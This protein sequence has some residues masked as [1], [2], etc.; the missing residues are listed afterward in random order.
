MMPSSLRRYWSTLHPLPSRSV[1]HDQSSWL[2]TKRAAW[3][4]RLWASL[5]CVHGVGDGVN[6]KRGRMQDAQIGLLG[7][8]SET[9][10]KRNLRMTISNQRW[11]ISQKAIDEVEV[12]ER[13]TYFDKVVVNMIRPP[14][15]SI[16]KRFRQECGSLTLTRSKDF[17]RE[18]RLVALQP[19]DVA[20]QLLDELF[21][22]SGKGDRVT[23][24]E[25]ALD[26]TTKTKRKANQL[27]AAMCSVIVFQHHG[28]KRVNWCKETRYTSPREWG[29]R[30]LVTYSDRRSKI[31]GMPCL[32]I[33]MRYRG[34]QVV[35]RCGVNRP[36][37]LLAI[38]KHQYWQRYL[39]LR[40]V[41]VHRLGRSLRSRSKA[42]RPEIDE[43][44]NDLDH[45]AGVRLAR[46][47]MR[48]FNKAF[49]NEVFLS[50]QAVI[51]KF[52]AHR[53]PLPRSAL[54]KIDNSRF[55]PPV[56]T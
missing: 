32:H 1:S 49:P 29:T 51:D 19:N 55:I 35:R 36:I 23:E 18:H 11:Q 42:K 53:W 24:F 20:I 2:W 47:I 45:S 17:E 12:S 44:G 54:Q 9:G 7:S 16:L 31:N 50:T 26:L 14:D 10:N 8:Q 39:V 5:A 22:P 48:A 33:E 28:D 13:L 56:I 34:S 25:L 38:D 15:K 27:H 4:R 43:D 41:D 6:S 30:Q 40:K 46:R 21:D 52:R 37:D 3:G